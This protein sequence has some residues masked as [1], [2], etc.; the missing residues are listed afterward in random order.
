MMARRECSG[1]SKARVQKISRRRTHACL[2]Q[3]EEVAS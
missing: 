1:L 3:I 2:T